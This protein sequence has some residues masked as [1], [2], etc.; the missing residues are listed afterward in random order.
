VGGDE[1]NPN[2]KKELISNKKLTL[3]VRLFFSC[4]QVSIRVFS[5][6][7]KEE[8]TGCK[9]ALG[10]RSYRIRVL[11]RKAMNAFQYQNNLPVK[12]SRIQEHKLNLKGG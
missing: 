10:E 2:V 5:S 4:R 6:K 11:M 8:N 3:Q 7:Y 9:R 12:K 1:L